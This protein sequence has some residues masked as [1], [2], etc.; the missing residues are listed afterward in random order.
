VEPGWSACPEPAGPAAVPREEVREFLDRGHGIPDFLARLRTAPVLDRPGPDGRFVGFR[1][2]AI[3]PELR[4]A[5]FGI[6]EGDIVT[7]IN[8]HGIE[9][10]DD[11]VEIWEGLYT[12]TR[13]TVSFLRGGIP[14]EASVD[15]TDVPVAITNDGVSRDAAP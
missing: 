7:A 11:A 3:D 8:G 4:C 5:V 14:Q 10:P 1:I 9:T 12:A 6:R 15:V 2:V 13:I